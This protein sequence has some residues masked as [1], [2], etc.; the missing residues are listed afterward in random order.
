MENVVIPNPQ[1]L[2]KLK[3]EFVRGGAG[4]LHLVSDFDRTLTKAFV[5]GKSVPSMISVFANGNFLTPDYTQKA[6]EL[7]SK[8]HP[9]EM[10][11]TLPIEERKKAMLEWW[12]THFELLIKSGL[13]KK[14]LEKVVDS[15]KIKFREGFEEFADFLKF[16]N[17]PLVIVSSSGLGID[18][19]SMRLEKAGKLS[20]NIHIVSNSFEWDSGG[21]VKAVKL[22]IIHVLNKD[23]TSIQKFPF[24]GAVKE[25]K[26]VILLG[27]SIED[28]GMVA[29]FNFDN[30][31]KIGFLNENIEENLE[32]Y[33]EKFDAVILNDSSLDSVNRLLKETIK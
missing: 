2:E 27:D 28:I 18:A 25:R 11:F 30:L 9:I 33:G 21:N 14:D 20:D 10:N 32:R 16:R 3:E 4:S 12:T 24:F 31:I 1:K 17:I 15:Q 23:E 13:N 5:D 22:P 7:Y 8:Y 26:N 19:I 6:Q 29:G